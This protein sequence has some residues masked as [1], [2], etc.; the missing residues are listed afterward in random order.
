MVNILAKR[1]GEARVRLLKV[2]L[3]CEGNE[4]LEWTVMTTVTGDFANSFTDGDNS[5]ILPSDTIK[6][7]IYSL[8][9]NSRAVC[10]EEFAQELIG[11]LLDWNTQIES[12]RVDIE[13]SPWSRPS[14]LDP[15]APQIFQRVGAEVWTTSAEGSRT[16]GIRIQSGLK[17]LVVI[18]TSRSSFEGFIKDSMTTLPETTERLLG[19]EAEVT[20]TYDGREHA[21]NGVRERVTDSLLATF[22]N[23]ESKSEQHTLYAIGQKILDSTPELVE[24]ELEFANLYYALADLSHFGQDNPCEIFVPRDE[25]HGYV[26]AKLGRS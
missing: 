16:A 22:A 6:N 21:F 8:A 19:V 13:Q 9:R 14:V 17:G 10:I 24:V 11:F 18:K 2:N 26:R 7:S 20:W 23:H 5:R 4:L 12:V 15:S 3:G 1:Y 25:P